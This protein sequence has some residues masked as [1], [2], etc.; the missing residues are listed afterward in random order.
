MHLA[1][2][3]LNGIIYSVMLSFFP[4]TTILAY[5]GLGGMIGAFHGFVISCVL[6]AVVAEDHPLRSF[7][8]K[9]MR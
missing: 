5:C 8:T 7:G 4:A 9:G 6:L 1:F 2:G 3:A